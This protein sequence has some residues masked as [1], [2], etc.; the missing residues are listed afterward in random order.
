MAHIKT[1]KG[2]LEYTNHLFDFG[3]KVLNPKKMLENL[4]ILSVYLDK[5]DINWG[6]AFGSLIGVV[7]NDDF[8]PWKP[9]F[10]IYIYLKKTKN[11]L[12]MFF[13]S[14]WMSDLNS[15]DTSVGGVIT[16]SEMVSISK[17]LC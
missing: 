1:S 16:L 14:Y 11:G 7:R 13:G 17:F 15:Y 8:Q 5:I 10:D 4:K 2:Y 6:P 3:K 9:V 12:K